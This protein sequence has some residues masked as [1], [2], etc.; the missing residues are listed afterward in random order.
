MTSKLAQL[1]AFVFMLLLSP[2]SLLAHDF[3]AVNEDGVIIYYNKISDTECEV[4]YY[5]ADSWSAKYSGTIVIP[6]IVRYSGQTLTVSAIGESAFCY[7]T[8]IFSMILPNS[9]TSIGGSAFMGCT[10]FWSLILPNSVK[11]IG[12]YAFSGCAYLH[13]I[14]LPNNLSSIEDYV[15]ASCTSLSS[16][17]LPNSIKSIGKDSFLGCDHLTSITLPNNLI[18][19]GDDA[20][21]GCSSLSTLTIPHTVSSIGKRAF[22]YCYNLSS[23][24]ILAETPPS[25]GINAFSERTLSDA[26]LY[27]PVGAVPLY[28]SSSPWRDFFTILEFE[29][30]PIPQCS[31]PSLTFTEGKL[32]LSC[33]T[34]G[35]IC[36]L[37]MNTDIAPAA[38]LTALNIDIYATAEG[39][40]PSEKVTI[41]LLD[42]LQTAA[43]CDLNGDGHLSAADVAILVQ[44]VLEVQ[45]N[46]QGPNE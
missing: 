29:P 1:L 9:I 36:H 24:N 20:F 18:T 22:E 46:K 26:I 7:C 17:E 34:P 3:S 10:G 28:T 21:C 23:I 30:E 27:V 11:S 2:L 40:E 15:F 25:A 12:S 43:S 45:I 31:L 6:N 5:G 8:N 42:L 44:Q 13:S 32:C 14:N 35:A 19:I 41:N 4:T 39:Y 33:D 37:T 38:D 16:I